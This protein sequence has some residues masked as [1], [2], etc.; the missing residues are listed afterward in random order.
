MKKITVIL[1]A[2]NEEAVIGQVL[3]SLK[4]TLKDLDGF[5]KQIV[6]VDDGSQDET[7]KTAKKN[8]ALVLKHILNRGLGAAI[9]TGLKYAEREKADIAV[10]IDSDGQHNTEDLKKV[11]KPVIKKEADVVIGS[12]FLEKNNKVPFLRRLILYGSNL[13][14]LLFFGIYTTDSQ[15][16]FRAFSKKAVEKISLRTQKMEVSSEIFEQIKKNNLKFEEIPISVVYTDYSKAKGQ[17][18]LNAFHVL[19]KLILKL[20]R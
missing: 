19:V 1:P 10:T 6:V 13:V 20:A 4:Q 2:Y 11:I 9:Q 12:R 8:G 14:T 7:A 5:E 3:V 17:D 16:G 15:S 18:N